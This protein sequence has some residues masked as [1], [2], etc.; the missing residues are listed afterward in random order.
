MG[1]W[2]AEDGASWTG[3]V[4]RFPITVDGSLCIMD[5]DNV[6]FEDYRPLF[7]KFDFA[8]INLHA[9]PPVFR[10]LDTQGNVVASS[11]GNSINDGWTYPF[12]FQGYDIDRV[13]F[14]S[15]EH[16]GAT[17]TK[18]VYVGMYFSTNSLHDNSPVIERQKETGYWDATIGTWNAVSEKWDSVG[19]EV[20]FD[21]TSPVFQMG[22]V[23]TTYQLLN[24]E[25]EFT[26]QDRLFYEVE[27]TV[28]TVLYSYS[29]YILSGQRIWVP[30]TFY[31]ST[32]IT[33]T[34]SA[35]GSFAVNCG[36]HDRDSSSYPAWLNIGI[37]TY[38]TAVQNMT[39]GVSYLT[40]EPTAAADNDFFIEFTLDPPGA[41]YAKPTL[42]WDLEDCDE[43][44]RFNVLQYGTSWIWEQPQIM[45]GMEFKYGMSTTTTG[46]RIFCPVADA[47]IEL[48]SVDFGGTEKIDDIVPVQ[49]ID[50]NNICTFANAGSASPHLE[51]DTGLL[52]KIPDK[53]R[54]T[55]TAHVDLTSITLCIKTTT[56]YTFTFE[57]YESLD[58]EEL[59][60][61]GRG[62]IEE[63]YFTAENGGSGKNIDVSK[64]EFWAGT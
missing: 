56:G 49:N 17:A 18:E 22:G 26:G 55:F 34:L 64:I 35:A 42:D 5:A 10:I 59:D 9:T 37:S 14:I 44:N 51:P 19:N 27:Y 12:T 2:T 39:V 54:L 36:F 62:E 13:E 1:N 48:T 61:L 3:S 21:F 8:A 16:E 31:N 29:G 43:D 40:L 58:E 20:E 7:V 52:T 25:F 53:V 45:P 33:V 15:V 46:F 24:F 28:S 50:A 32:G 23:G 11:S 41:A 47:Q 30:Q 4:W 6:F 57:D 38:F 60:W 63:L